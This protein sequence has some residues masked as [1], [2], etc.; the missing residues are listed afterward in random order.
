MNCVICNKK[1]PKN[2][3]LTCSHIC[4]IKY[5]RSNEYQRLNRKK[6]D[7]KFNNRCPICNTLIGKNSKYCIKHS[8]KYRNK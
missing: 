3:K 6:R 1:V 8:M 7:E 2:R 4:S 5:L